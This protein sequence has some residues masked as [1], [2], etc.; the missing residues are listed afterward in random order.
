VLRHTVTADTKYRTVRGGVCY[1]GHLTVITRSQQ[2]IEKQRTE[3]RTR[4][5]KKSEEKYVKRKSQRKKAEVRSEV[6]SL[7]G[8]VTVRLKVL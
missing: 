7:C 4:S 5:Q 8:T 6:F 2:R 1:H 3:V